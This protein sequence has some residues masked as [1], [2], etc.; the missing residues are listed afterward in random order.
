MEL[1]NSRAVERHGERALSRRPLSCK[2]C[3]ALRVAEHATDIA[4]DIG[5]L[6][7]R[8]LSAL[9]AEH[10]V[11]VRSHRRGKLG[12]QVIG[13]DLHPRA[14]ALLRYRSAG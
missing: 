1:T 4:K 14:P 6:I 7:R 3:S 11:D 13:Y 5:G 12:F 2:V 10:R 9:A 8:L